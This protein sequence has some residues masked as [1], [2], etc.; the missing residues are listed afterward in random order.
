MKEVVSTLLR[1]KL[2]FRGIISSIIV[3]GIVVA[4][5]A[6]SLLQLGSFFHN[7]DS[8]S[9]ATL[10]AMTQ[11]KVDATTLPPQL[12][13]EPLISV[14][15]DD[16]FESM[17]S[18]AI[19]LLQKYGI[20]STQYVLA[21]KFDD[22]LYVSAGQVGKMQQAG[23]EIAC[24]TMTHSDLTKLDDARLDYELHQCKTVLTSRFGVIN[25]F[26]SPYGS[27]NTRTIAAIG[28]YFD[29]QRNTN[30]DPTNG[31]TNAD[32]N[33]ADN[34]DRY[35]II[36]VTVRHNTSVEELKQLVAFAKSYNGWVVLTY[37]Q[38]DEGSGS[39]FGVDPG[40]LERQFDYL[41]R[42]DVRIVTMHEALD[43]SR[44]H[45]IGYGRS[46]LQSTGLQNVGY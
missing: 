30:G 4:Y 13:Q 6:F 23:H 41:S 39:Q 27:A 43:F 25:D 46:L 18:A 1:K 20:H 40:K 12:F 11:R 16:G 24:H 22:P 42:T 38:A 26:A 8:R 14:T 2:N 9:V 10:P 17:Y 32:V 21:G 33:T 34:F 29:S 3:V 7:S 15:F 5:P 44:S 28:R 45:E 31:V 36:G 37:H 19:P 35:N